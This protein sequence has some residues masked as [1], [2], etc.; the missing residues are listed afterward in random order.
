M[1]K[2]ELAGRADEL[3]EVADDIVGPVLGLGAEMNVDAKIPRDAAKE[4]RS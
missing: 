4:V 3:P 2:E 1:A